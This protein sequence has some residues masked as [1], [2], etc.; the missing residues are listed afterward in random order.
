MQY[1]IITVDTEGDSQWTW[2]KGDPVTTK[3]ARMIPFF[4]ELCEE[5]NFKPVY[6][7]NYEMVCDK[8]LVNYLKPKVD[9]DL[10]EIGIHIHAWNSPPEYQLNESFGGNAYITEYPRNVIV[11]KLKFLKN[12]IESE[13]SVKVV[14]HRS[15]R[16]ATNEEYFEIL[17]ELGI[18]VDCSVVPQIDLSNL[19][20]ASVSKGINYYKSN[21][22]PY[23]IT[24]GIIEVPMTTRRIRRITKGSFKHK[25]KTLLFGDELWMRLLSKNDRNLFYLKQYVEKEH[26]CE[27]VEF[28]IHSSELLPGGN[29]Y[30]KT[31]EDVTVLMNLLRKVFKE[32]YDTGYSGITLKEYYDLFYK[33]KMKGYK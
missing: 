27:Y 21:V 19:P 8:T 31:D 2:K 23:E 11:D 24:S 3:N 5:F 17:K 28:M 29:P 26:V 13:F 22:Y 12:K 4:Q 16:W 30:F 10:C 15:G 7:I 33:R 18:K 14:S 25:L 6:L 20:G 32:F 9:N 1:F